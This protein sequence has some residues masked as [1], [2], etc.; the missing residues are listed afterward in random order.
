MSEI[1]KAVALLCSISSGSGN[2]IQWDKQIKTIQS[3]QK[4]CQKELLTCAV[5]GVAKAKSSGKIVNFTDS[6]ISGAV[7]DCLIK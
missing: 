1:I 7:I 6:E 3:Y 2:S 4:Q 5:L